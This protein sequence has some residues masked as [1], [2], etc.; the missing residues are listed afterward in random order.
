M[1]YLKYFLIYILL[2]FSKISHSQSYNDDYVRSLEKKIHQQEL[3]IDSM[4]YYLQLSKIVMLKQNEKRKIW[5]KIAASELVIAGGVVL[6]I[7]TGLWVPVFMGVVVVEMGLI[8]EG[9]YRLNLRDLKK[10]RALYDRDKPD[11]KI[12]HK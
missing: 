10:K 2:F 11:G 8:T 3:T 12:G 5:M 4:D 1:G 9:K 7:S 6:S